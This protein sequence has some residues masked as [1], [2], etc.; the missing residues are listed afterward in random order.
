MKQSALATMSQRSQNLKSL[1]ELAKERS[2]VANAEL[3]ASHAIKANSAQLLAQQEAMRTKLRNEALAKQAAISAPKTVSFS[4]PKPKKVL[5]AQVKFG[6][7]KASGYIQKLIEMDKLDPEAEI[8]DADL[9]QDP[10]RYIQD[11]LYEKSGRVREGIQKVKDIQKKQIV[12]SAVKKYVRNFKSLFN[13]PVDEVVKFATSWKRDGVEGAFYSA[14]LVTELGF[15]YLMKKYKNDALIVEYDSYL[16]LFK[17]GLSYEAGETTLKRGK[18]IEEDISSAIERGAEVIVIPFTLHNKGFEE[19]FK[20]GDKTGLEAHA[21]MLIYRPKKNI[22]ERF[23]PHG[24]Y[25]S[26]PMS[27]ELSTTKMNHA[28]DTYFRNNLKSITAEDKRGRPFI[29]MPPS[30]LYLRENWQE[31]AD[32]DSTMTGF[33][34]VENEYQ[35]MNKLDFPGFCAMWSLYYLELVLKFPNMDGQELVRKAHTALMKEGGPK[36]FLE[37]MLGFIE[38]FE[39]ELKNLIKATVK[40]ELG[41]KVPTYSFKGLDESKMAIQDKEAI[42][43]YFELQDWYNQQ[44]Q[45][46]MTKQREEKFLKTGAGVMNLGGSKAS[47]YVQ[48]LIAM[49]KDGLEVFDINKMKWASDNLKALGIMVEELDDSPAEFPMGRIGLKENREGKVEP[50]MEHSKLLI[51]PPVKKGV[52]AATLF[53]ATYDGNNMRIRKLAHHF[54]RGW[55]LHDKW[56]SGNPLNYTGRVENGKYYRNKKSGAEA[57]IE[58]FTPEKFFESEPDRL[59]QMDDYLKSDYFK[60]THTNLPAEFQVEAL[61]IGPKKK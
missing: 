43:L 4:L 39:K 9:V 48:K 12:K 52:D 35:D 59:K 1:Q 2:A 54:L 58:L 28:I 61:P 37:H 11:Q 56:N 27:W 18:F 40:T 47:G 16:R 33:Q 50:K 17:A 41:H 60:R 31:F 24:E 49:Y 30:E 38:Y 55:D 21:N 36:R 10:S 53:V 46:L 29:F 3:Q 5:A 32:Y 34:L 22:L 57:N 25:T 19:K 14:V 45:S 42:N 13:P 6:G 51:E 7:S 20:T 23:E 26:V 8:F 44:I 15:L